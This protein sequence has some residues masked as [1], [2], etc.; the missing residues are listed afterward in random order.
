MMGWWLAMGVVTLLWIGLVVWAM[1]IA[2]R[3]RLYGSMYGLRSD[4]AGDW[5]LSVLLAQGSDEAQIA[6]LL[7]TDYERYE[8]VVAID[9]VREAALLQV[10]L[11]RYRLIR[12]TG[13][14]TGEL[15]APPITALYRS[16]LRLF[17]RLVVVD[18]RCGLRCG[19]LN[20]TAA[21]AAYE[22]LLP[23]PRGCCLREGAVA[24][25]VAEADRV[26]GPPAAWVLCAG[27][28]T[29]CYRRSALVQAGGFGRTWRLRRRWWPAGVV[30]NL[31]SGQRGMC[32]RWGW[33]VAFLGVVGVAVQGEDWLTSL[34]A[35]GTFLAWWLLL[36]RLNRVVDFETESHDWSFCRALRDKSEVEI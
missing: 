34:A 1:R 32:A 8:V 4:A 31:R 27:M 20:A 13:R 14:A 3:R 22:L 2:A 12:V 18:V 36:R 16:R 11:A 26:A 10:L 35:T 9:G 23:L 6:A 28:P 25:L 7:A 29:T 30:R 17:R 33:R 5:G 21:T 24:W 15:T 19:R